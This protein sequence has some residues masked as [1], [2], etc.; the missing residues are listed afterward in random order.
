MDGG[1]RISVTGPDVILQ[2]R[3]AQTF[4]L[5][6]HEL[7]TNAAKYGSL[8]ADVGHLS[9][10]WHLS[11]QQL[12]F[13]WHESDGP[14]VI[15]PSKRGFG[16]QI[17]FASVQDQLRGRVQL[18][19]PARGLICNLSIPLSTLFEALASE[20]SSQRQFDAVRDAA[21]NKPSVFH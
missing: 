9:V 11:D 4:A 7:A 21:P 2:P 15:K 19:W 5:A 3:A 6:L 18:E 20:I 13:K 10:K 8:S 1:T 12:D 17:I 14:P 16:T